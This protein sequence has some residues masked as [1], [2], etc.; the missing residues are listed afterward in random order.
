MLSN[1]QKNI[2]IRAIEIRLQSGEDLEAILD[3]YTKLALPDKEEIRKMIK[4]S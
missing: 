2:I 4:L 3:S 1:I